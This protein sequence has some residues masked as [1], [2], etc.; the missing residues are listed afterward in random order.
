[1]LAEAIDDVAV[2]PVPIDQA[3][4]RGLIGRLKSAK[5]FGHYRGLAPA[6]VDALSW[7]MVRLSQ[8]AYDHA[9]EISAIDLNPVIVH[10]AGHGVSVV[11]ALITKRAAAPQSHHALE[12]EE[13]AGVR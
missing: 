11:D 10:S 3:Q 9:D 6:D 8:F 13:K 2:A 4:A 7:L 5:I 12:V 1:V